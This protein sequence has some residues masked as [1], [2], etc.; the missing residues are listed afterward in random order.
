[1][2]RIVNWK[3]VLVTTLLTYVTKSLKKT[4]PTHIKVSDLYHQLENLVGIVTIHDKRTG[5][6]YYSTLP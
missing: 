5:I 6:N 1:M 3:E 4:L 2:N